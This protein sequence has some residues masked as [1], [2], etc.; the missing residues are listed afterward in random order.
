MKPLEVFL[1]SVA[2]LQAPLQFQPFP[3]WWFSVL[4]T[5]LNAAYAIAIR[6]YLLI[7]LIGLM[8]YMTGMCDELGKILVVGGVGIYLV[9]PYLVSLFAA[10]AGIEPITLE[11]ATSAW[12]KVFA[13]SDSELIALIVTLAEVLAAI[14]CLAG[15]IMYFVPSSNEL[16]S[17]GQSLIVRA[18]ILA[19][20]LVF[21]QAS[22]WI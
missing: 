19:P 9:G 22:P 20:V 10:V 5:V 1:T 3:S 8:L 21:F 15:A 18:L 12:L 16:R 11:S 4:E 7:V 14:C 17:R 6:G 2:I 13:M